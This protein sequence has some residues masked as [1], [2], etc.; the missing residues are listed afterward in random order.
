MMCV[1]VLLLLV[2]GFTVSQYPANPDDEQPVR[3]VASRVA[4]V[5]TPSGKAEMPLNLSRDWNHPQPKVIQAVI[6]F[7]GRERDVNGNYRDLLRA[8]DLAGGDAYGTSILIAPQFLNPED[9][10][11]HRLSDH[12]LRWRQGTWEAGAE[13]AGPVP[14]SSFEII[15]SITAH[16]CDRTLFPNLKRIVLAGHSG[17]GQLILR[18]AIVGRAERIAAG[19]QLRYVVANPA[20]YLYF[21]DERPKFDAGSFHFAN[22]SSVSCPNF[23]HWRYGPLRLRF[24]YVQQSAGV[25]WPA[26]EDAFAKKDVVYLLG[27]AD[28]DPNDKELDLTCAG[29]LEG[30]NRFLRGQ[31]YYVWLR[32]RHP[33]D[34]NQRMWFVPEVAHSAKK[35]FTS[36][37]GVAALFRRA[38]CVNRD[39]S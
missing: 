23:N 36:E 11:L 27:T 30:P 1:R 29:E 22:A 33:A 12:I 2:I 39:G 16:L 24:Q 25:G 8:A 17:G 21:S 28:V 14:I 4:V 18:Y 38:S 9:V 20:S 35:M 32:K 3:T 37:C 34:W 15:D 6:V 19:R 10:R 7:H 5:M 31:A 26:L 13:A